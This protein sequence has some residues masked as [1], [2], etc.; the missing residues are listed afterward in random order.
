MTRYTAWCWGMTIDALSLYSLFRSFQIPLSS[1]VPYSQPP[2]AHSPKLTNRRTRNRRMDTYQIFQAGYPLTRYESTP[3]SQPLNPS[4]DTVNGLHVAGRTLDLF[5][6][7]HIGS[8]IDALIQHCIGHPSSFERQI[9]ELLNSWPVDSKALT[10][11]QLKGL[12]KGL[13]KKYGKIIHYALLSISPP[14]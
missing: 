14:A 12:C 1:L 10:S 13:T 2:I 7:K 11:E 5:L 8:H 9:C 4:M 3:P 6:Q